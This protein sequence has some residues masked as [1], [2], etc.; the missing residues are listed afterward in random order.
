MKH[1]LFLIVSFF[2]SLTLSA[3]WV[4]KTVNN[5]I[6]EPYKIAYCKSSDNSAVL[7]LEKV[8]TSVAFYL[9]GGYHCDESTTVDIGLT[10]NGEIRRYSFDVYVSDDKRAVFI[11][12][13]LKSPDNIEFLKHFRS[14]SRLSIRI[15][16]S[17]CHDDYYQFNMSGSTRAFDF[18]SRN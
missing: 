9:S 17:H 16:E 6:D 12:D 15:N 2:F 4:A 1:K 8:D 11:I 13:D 5:G 3:Q 14:A 7:K 18:I 10:V